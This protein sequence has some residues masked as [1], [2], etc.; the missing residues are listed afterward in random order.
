MPYGI[1]QCHLPPG[2]GYIPAYIPEKLVLDLA[3]P[4]GCKA[5]MTQLAGHTTELVYPSENGHGGHPYE[6]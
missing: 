1:T 3:T 4:E 2:R 6:Y 5:E